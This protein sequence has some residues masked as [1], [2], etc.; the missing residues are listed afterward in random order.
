MTTAHDVT[1]EKIIPAI[2]EELKKTKFTKPDWAKNVKTG[3][4]KE[5]APED[6]DWWW[7]RA[8]SILRKLYVQGPTGSRKL[9]VEYGGRKNR[10]VK[11]EEFRKAGG[12]IL[13]VILQQFDDAGLTV[14]DGKEKKGRLLTPKGRSFVDKIAS[15][16][17]Q[18]NVG[19]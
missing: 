10:G 3:A 2:A 14:K 12:K 8:A 15:K 9:R 1:P 4:H 7:M 16:I 13:R 19:A 11:P 17:A 5:R 6:P 18:E